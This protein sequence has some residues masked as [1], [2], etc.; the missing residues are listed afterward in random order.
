MQPPYFRPA[1]QQREAAGKDERKSE[2]AGFRKSRE[3]KNR[4]Y[5]HAKIT[6]RRKSSEW[7]VL[8]KPVAPLPSPPPAENFVLE[9]P[10][11]LRSG[12]R[13]QAPASLTPANRLNSGAGEGI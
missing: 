4:A 5:D 7:S 10:R 11:K 3:T 1:D 13:L 12:F 8:E 9:F 2:K 6:T